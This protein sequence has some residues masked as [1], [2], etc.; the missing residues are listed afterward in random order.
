MAFVAC[1]PSCDSAGI[2]VQPAS[3][4][5]SD[6]LDPRALRSERVIMSLPSSLRRPDPPVSTTPPD[7]PR[8]LVI[9]EALPDDLVW[10]ATE[11]FPALGQHSVHA[12]R[13]LYA[14]RRGRSISPMSP[15]P[16]RLP[17]QTSE[18][19]PPRSRP[20]LLSGGHFDASTSVRLATA[21]AVARPPGP[22]RPGE[23]LPSG[24]R[25]LSTQASPRKGRPPRESGIATRHP[26]RTP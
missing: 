26:G 1:A 22:I 8:A 4:H 9:Q 15:C 24:R 7:F 10:A 16:H 23:P 14:G 20:R 12:C 11:T 2:V 17:H 19:A 3:G 25:G 21:R 5:D 13:H 18:S 6:H